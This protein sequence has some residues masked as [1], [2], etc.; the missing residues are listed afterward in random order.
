ME[1]AV[2]ELLTAAPGE[3]YELHL[4]R[5]AFAPG[6]AGRIARC[7][8]LADLDDHLAHARIAGPTPPYAWARRHITSAQFLRHESASA[9]HHET[10]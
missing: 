5:I 1:L 3:D 9:T 10:G 4:L 7:A 2:R 8:K 6:E